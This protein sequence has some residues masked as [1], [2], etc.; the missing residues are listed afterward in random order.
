MSNFY[1]TRWAFD[2]MASARS[3]A[4]GK[5]VAH[6]TR[7]YDNGDGSYRLRYH[8]TDI[9]TFNHDGSYSLANGGWNTVTTIQRIREYS[10]AHVISVKGEWYVQLQPRK[11]DP[12]PEIVYPAV[13]APFDRPDDYVKPE[14]GYASYRDEWNIQRRQ[15]T[16]DECM[17]RFGS[18]E[19]WRE[20]RK[21]QL[22]A[23]KE[24]LAADKAWDERNYIPFYDGIIVDSDGYALR[25]TTSGPS[26]AKLR[27]HEKAVERTKKR[28]ATYIDGYISRLAKGM[29]MPGQGDCW[30][31]LFRNEQTGQTWGDMGDNDHLHS[32]MTERYY[33]PMLAVNALKEAGYQDTGVFIWLDMHPETQTMGGKDDRPKP[34][35]TVRRALTKYM[36]K[37]LVPSAPMQ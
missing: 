22:A 19:Q 2:Q 18:V 25:L 29:P 1:N 28:I 8:N 7:L 31:C 5:P 21:R 11:G 27:R 12:R 20:E 23:R 16:Y 13:A 17:E 4:N 33:V 32:H 6:N 9:I 35:D 3:K 24:Y 26:R 30:F 10:P 37:R 14:V 34:Y 15:S 36:T